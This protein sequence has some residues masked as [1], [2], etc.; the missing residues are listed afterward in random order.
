MFFQIIS[1][2]I[3][4]K[5]IITDPGSLCYTSD[6][7]IRNKYRSINSHF[8][9]RKFGYHP[10]ENA[11]PFSFSN[12][13]KGKVIN[14]DKDIFFGKISYKNCNVFRKIEILSTGLK[15]NDYCSNGK[16]ENYEVLDNKELISTS[17][18][19]LGKDRIIQTS[20]K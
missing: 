8:A 9:P 11:F 10:K 15:I 12:F 13:L 2:V 14:V 6:L 17:Y 7:S 16:L 19:V 18:R 1:I 4:K 3:D 20:L 5:N